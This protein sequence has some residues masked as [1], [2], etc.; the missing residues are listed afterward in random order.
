MLAA[1]LVALAVAGGVPSAAEAVTGKDYYDGMEAYKRGDYTTAYRKLLPY[2]KKGIAPVQ[3]QIGVMHANG[4]GVPA[5]KRK[6]VEWYRKAAIQAFGGAQATLGDM[7]MRGDGVEK[8][9]AVAGWWFERAANQG[10]G[11]AQYNMAYL[12]INGEGRSKDYVQAYAWLT[13][14]VAGQYR[15]AA[16]LRNQLVRAM[17]Q[18]QVSRAVRL[19]RGQVPSRVGAGVVINNAGYVLTAY[20]LVDGCRTVTAYGDQR[21]QMADVKG[22]DIENDLALLK[23]SRPTAT[24]AAIPWE[25]TPQGG[26]DVY[27]AGVQANGAAVPELSIGK[28]RL[29][30]LAGPNGDRRFIKLAAAMPSDVAGAPVL[31]GSGRL[32][33]IGLGREQAL[34]L[35]G[36]RQGPSKRHE[37]AVG[38]AT[39]SDFLKYYDV[40]HARAKAGGPALDDDALVERTRAVTVGIAC[41][42]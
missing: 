28:G 30:G 39:F 23:L 17:S 25:K 36:A 11:H 20:H 15:P 21:P 40:A 31:D 13:R 9:L 29:D 3:Y 16:A 42:R 19:A 12:Y 27:H 35:T 34:A 10:Y 5:D 8:N 14:A 6:A 2:A 18:Q 1:C 22:F 7:Y 24:A 41:R 37:F 33:G 26:Q 32:I 4:Y 38:V